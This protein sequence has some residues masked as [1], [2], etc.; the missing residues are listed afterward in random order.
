MLEIERGSNEEADNINCLSVSSLTLCNPSVLRQGNGDTTCKNVSQ[1][2]WEIF[3]SER[4]GYECSSKDANSWQDSISSRERRGDGG[5]SKDVSLQQWEMYNSER[6][7]DEC[8]SK[9]VKSS[10]DLIYNSERRGDG[11]SIKDVN[12]WHL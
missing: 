4:R 2:Q 7:G 11:G 9:D 10:Q 1:G 5:S 6:R 12:L 3:N 8:S